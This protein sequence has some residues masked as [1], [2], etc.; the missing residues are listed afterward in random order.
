MLTDGYLYQS[1]DFLG[2]FK[3]CN[4]KVDVFEDGPFLYFFA[5]SDDL[6]ELFKFSTLL[7]DAEGIDLGLSL[8]AKASTRL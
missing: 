3:V 7:V 1:E 5:L 6:N 8:N 2:I 4:V